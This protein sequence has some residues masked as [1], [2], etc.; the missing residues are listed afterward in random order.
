MISNIV[1]ISRIIGS[2][3][4]VSFYHDRFEFSS[5]IYPVFSLSELL[6]V[7]PS[8]RFEK[9][10]DEDS[11]SFV[12]MEVIDEI[13]GVIDQ[14]RFTIVKKA[15]GF[16][17]FEENDL[18]WAKITPCMQNGKSA[19]AKNLRNGYGCGST[20][21]YVLRPKSNNILIEY[22][23]FILRDKRVLESAKK[24]FGGSAGQQRV[25][26]GYLKSIKLPL[27]PIEIQEKIVAR[28]TSAYIEKRAKEEEAKRAFEEEKYKIEKLITG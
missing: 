6:Y 28:Y 23:H 11:I 10:S 9:L 2:R 12:P 4:D 22:V 20:E 15:K 19:I 16:T 25:S 24:S 3:L 18:L 17:R 1:K 5:N 13:N 7:N 8:V 14:E 27:P 26:S 21:F